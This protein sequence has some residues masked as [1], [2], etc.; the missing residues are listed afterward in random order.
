MIMDSER[1][2]GIKGPCKITNNFVIDVPMFLRGDVRLK[3][4]GVDVR[5]L[6]ECSHNVFFP[7]KQTE[8][9]RGYYVHGRGIKNLPFHDK[10][11][12]LESSIYFSENPDA[13]FVPKAELGTDLMTSKSVTPGEDDIKLLYADPMFDLEAMKGKVFRF[14]PGSPA[15]KLGIEPIDLSNVGSSLAR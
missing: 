1:G 3:F 2:I 7:P 12:R 8:E 4:S 11:P 13:P 14:L 10:L 15:E 6:I 9:T 5:K